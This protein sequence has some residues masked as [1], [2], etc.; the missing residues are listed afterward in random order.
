MLYKKYARSKNDNGYNQLAE[1]FENLASQV[2]DRFYQT[3]PDICVK[4]IR[5]QIPAYGN[6]TCLDFA[7]AADAKQ[8][9]AQRG[10]Q[11][12]FNSMWFVLNRI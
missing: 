2:F 6:A 1:E 3:D 11:D 9:I 8:F 5:R 10:V 12:L 4:A 7:I